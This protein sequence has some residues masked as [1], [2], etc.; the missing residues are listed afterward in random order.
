MPLLILNVCTVSKGS[1]DVTVKVYF[2]NFSASVRWFV[3]IFNNN[4]LFFE[5]FGTRGVAARCDEG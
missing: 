2:T 1:G 5:T 3:P 4:L